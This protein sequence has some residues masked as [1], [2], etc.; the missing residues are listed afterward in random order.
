[1]KG[2]TIRFRISHFPILEPLSERIQK[3]RSATM[4]PAVSARKTSIPILAR[5][6][7]MT[8]KLVAP[9]ESPSPTRDIERGLK[10]RLIGQDRAIREITRALERAFAGV[11][12]PQPHNAGT[13][14]CLPA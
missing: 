7:A 9:N 6:K 1:M 3:K 14:S 2:M 4:R 8:D 11:D 10:E 13:A 12:N 5:R